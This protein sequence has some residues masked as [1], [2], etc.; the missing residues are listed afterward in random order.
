[1]RMIVAEA[2]AFVPCE[3]FFQCSK[4]HPRGHKLIPRAPREHREMLER[5]ARR[6]FERHTP[7]PTARPSQTVN[8]V[9][10]L[11]NAS[12]SRSDTTRVTFVSIWMKNGAKQ[13]LNFDTKRGGEMSGRPNSK[14]QPAIHAFKC[15][16][17]DHVLFWS[18]FALCCTWCI[19]YC[20]L[21]RRIA[22]FT[23]YLSVHKN[24]HLAI[25]S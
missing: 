20:S 10:S 5:S 3:P 4:H 13:L 19:A 1:V 22:L 8:E 23:I 14:G 15:V 6:H 18:S 7:D 16:N 2:R 9:S 25:N 21:L 11:S 24:G 12:N 17:Y